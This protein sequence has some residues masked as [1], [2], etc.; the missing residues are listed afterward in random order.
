MGDLYADV[1]ERLLRA[2]VVA[3]SWY[4]SHDFSILFEKKF[5]ADT[6]RM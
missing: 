5:G 2:N 6:K 1:R 3:L 4:M